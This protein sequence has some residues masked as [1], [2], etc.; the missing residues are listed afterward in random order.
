VPTF[1][2]LEKNKEIGR[3]VETPQV[4]IGQDILNILEGGV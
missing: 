3:I 4:S 2:L 1:V